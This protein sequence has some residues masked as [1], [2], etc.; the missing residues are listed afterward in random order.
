MLKIRFD[1]NLGSREK[2]SNK[3]LVKEYFSLKNVGINKILSPKNVWTK[4]VQPRYF[5][6]K[7]NLG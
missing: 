1:L 7:N 3:P 6:S 2:G 5:L 4:N